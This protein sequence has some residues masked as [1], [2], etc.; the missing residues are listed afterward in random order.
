MN[1]FKQYIETH[2]FEN[3]DE[4]HSLISLMLICNGHN[5]NDD[6]FYNYGEQIDL[7]MKMYETDYKNVKY[8]LNMEIKR[9][10]IIIN[11]NLIGC[12][13]FD[14]ILNHYFDYKFYGG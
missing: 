4:K 1:E 14:V 10:D 8:C 11:D 7:I 2:D 13:F 6:D 12:I 3:F 5:E 9:I